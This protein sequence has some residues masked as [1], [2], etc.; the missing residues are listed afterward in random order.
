MT[1]R[2]GRLAGEEEEEEEE[3]EDVVCRRGIFFGKSMIM[4]LQQ[5][6]NLQ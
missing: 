4:I 2:R 6:L 5:N 1:A 3:E